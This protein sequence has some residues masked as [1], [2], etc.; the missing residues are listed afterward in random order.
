MEKDFTD[1]DFTNGTEMPELTP[2][3]ICSLE[4]PEYCESC[5]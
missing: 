4:N 3:Q 5:Q 2:A 1:I